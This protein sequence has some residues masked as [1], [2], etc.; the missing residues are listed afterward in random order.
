MIGEYTEGLVGSSFS[1]FFSILAAGYTIGPIS[2][3]VLNPAAYFG[4]NI[5]H[6]IREDDGEHFQDV[7]VYILGPLLGGAIAAILNVIFLLGM[8]SNRDKVI[9]PNYDAVNPEGIEEQE[10]STNQY[11][12]E[13]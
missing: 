2:G 13:N 11:I 9:E 4:I 5:A 7:W 10:G 3:S 1:I 12:V 6:A 8:S